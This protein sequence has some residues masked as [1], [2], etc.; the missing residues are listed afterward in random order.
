M[1]KRED[2]PIEGYEQIER[3]E[4]PFALPYVVGRFQTPGV[5]TLG[6]MDATDPKT[7]SGQDS[8]MMLHFLITPEEVSW[9]MDDPARLNQLARDLQEHLPRSRYFT[10]MTSQ[11]L[12][13]NCGDLL[14][15]DRLERDQKFEQ[16]RQHRLFQPVL[17]PHTHLEE[18][19]RELL[20][21]QKLSDD[22]SN[23]HSHEERRRQRTLGYHL[24]RAE[25][26]YVAIDRC[27]PREMWPA[28]D[29]RLGVGYLFTTWEKAKT[30]CEYYE[31]DQSHYYR[32]QL[33]LQRDYP[34][35]FQNCEM[36]S[37]ERFVVDDGAEG[38]EIFRDCIYPDTEMSWLEKHNQFLREAT[39]HAASLQ[40]QISA[41]WDETP[42]P[43]RKKLWVQRGNWRE[44][45]MSQ[46][47]QS[48]LYVPL[49][50]PEEV[51]EKLEDCYVFS[52]KGIEFLKQQLKN[53]SRPASALVPPDFVGK[54]AAIQSHEKGDEEQRGLLP[55]RWGTINEAEGAWALA[56]TSERLCRAYMESHE[57]EENTMAIVAWEEIE[58]QI[59]E[60]RGLLLDLNGL[61]LRLREADIKRRQN[62]E[63]LMGH[64]P[65]EA[66]G[67]E[68]KDTKPKS[69][70]LPR[71]T[72]TAAEQ[73]LKREQAPR[74]LGKVLDWLRRTMGRPRTDPT[75]PRKNEKRG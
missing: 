48:I 29:H 40:G 73:A 14:R 71:E 62:P 75:N 10:G 41:Y 24:R 21:L 58:E 18:A 45:M 12:Q 59:Q 49:A 2:Y 72:E 64:D 61:T 33:L 66:S 3:I 1:P 37:I 30:A 23:A 15:E 43:L 13:R 50:L 70:E 69:A 26:L 36:L 44:A 65:L 46:L 5:Y 51:R 74:G 57:E 53:E 56:F 32:P 42:E 31:F 6:V 17:S 47:R 8:D 60:E 63:M 22:N 55:L 25:A 4:G 68:E 20:E 38:V 35:F 52:Q 9:R 7:W 27:S 54:T 16:W 34:R 11:G 28:V 39:L 67:L 19:L